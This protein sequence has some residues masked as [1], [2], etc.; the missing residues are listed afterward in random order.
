[1]PEPLVLA[2]PPLVGAGIGLFTNWLAIKMLFRPL[3]ERRFLGIRVPFTPGI[4]PRERQRIS[5]SLGDIVA[6]DLLDE[7]TI[8]ARLRSPSFK[9]AVRQAVMTAARSLFA[10]SPNSLG[11]GLD[12]SMIAAIRATSIHALSGIGS[13]EAFLRGLLSG[14]TAAFDVA[15]PMPLSTVVPPGSI[16]SM[17]AALYA[18]GMSDHLARTI[19][20]VV[21]DALGRA[22]DS[23]KMVASFVPAERLRDLASRAMVSAWP[24]LKTA[25]TGVLEDKAVVRSMERSGARLIRRALDRFNAVQRFFIGLGQYDRAIMENM[26][27]TIQDFTTAV[28]DLLAEDSTRNAVV[29]RIGD[30]VEAAVTKPLSSI[31]FLSDAAE[32]AKARDDLSAVLRGAVSVLDPEL[33]DTLAGSLMDAH[34]LGELIDANPGLAERLVPALTGWLAARFDTS[35]DLTIPGEVSPARRIA[36]AFASA[37]VRSFMATVGAEPLAMTLS[38]D[39]DELES[40][41]ASVSDGLIELAARESSGILRSL[42]VRALVVDKIDSLDM[43]EVE[44]MILRVVDKELGAITA[45]GGILGAIIGIFQSLFMFLR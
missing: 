44:R 22:A 19:A 21:M 23:G 29:A 11:G 13:S 36:S 31:G 3:L 10:S 20:N 12:A 40:L 27:A 26:P 17:A 25:V 38:I 32:N 33:F 28:K 45:F 14:T 5:Q 15:R 41:S 6:T 35:R 4:L 1:M 43:I 39:D 8:S 16:R 30:I 7:S 24:A 9:T 34:T 2:L 42:D 37:F 18:D